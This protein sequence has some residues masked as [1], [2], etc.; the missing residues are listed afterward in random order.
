MTIFQPP[1]I[2]RSQQFKE[3][4]TSI[5][6]KHI[7]RHNK[8]PGDYR[9]DENRPSPA[10]TNISNVALSFGAEMYLF[11]KMLADHS[12]DYIFAS[13]A[14]SK[15]SPMERESFDEDVKDKLTQFHS[16][17]VQLGHRVN[18]SD[19]LRNATERSHLSRVQEGLTVYLKQIIAMV[20]LLK[21]EHLQR[22]HAKS[23]SQNLMKIAQEAGHVYKYHRGLEE[24]VHGS[25]LEF[26]DK[27]THKLRE[28]QAKHPCM[29]YIPEEVNSDYY[30]VEEKSN[31]KIQK[32]DLLDGEDAG[33]D[34]IDELDVLIVPQDKPVQNRASPI[35][36]KEEVRNRRRDVG[37]GYDAERESYEKWR[38]EQGEQ[39]AVEF[40][41]QAELRKKEFVKEDQDDEILKLQQHL[42]EIASLHTVFSE[43]VL[44][45]D[46]DVELIHDHALHTTENITDGNEWIR[47][48]I[49]NSGKQRAF[50]LFSIVVLSFA[51]LFIDWYNP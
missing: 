7:R 48:A 34:G 44:E 29:Q 17:N 28:I 9:R 12:Q 10:F 23:K 47:K 14:Y 1:F 39:F 21:K 15:M 2:D 46:R 50:L 11:R 8:P 49:T 38:D 18:S 20:S 19:G 26:S 13:R 4:A 36:F 31:V 35:I 42:T 45:Q 27:L 43:K 22:L 30:L 3:L 6:Q 16:I 25:E 51:L 37:G 41:Q 40:Q 24:L 32:E 33:W 5:E